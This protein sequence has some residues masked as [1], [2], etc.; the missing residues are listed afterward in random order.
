MSGADLAQEATDIANA[1]ERAIEGK[2]S[3]AVMYALGMVLA[4][5]VARAQTIRRPID[6]TLALLRSIIVAE[7]GRQFPPKDSPNA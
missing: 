3:A 6:E 2:P 7:L 5:S 4:H 1:I